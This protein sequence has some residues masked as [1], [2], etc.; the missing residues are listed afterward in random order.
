[1]GSVVKAEGWEGRLHLLIEGARNRAFAWGTHDCVTFAADA[2]IAQTGHDPISDVRG[3]WKTAR[4]AQLAMRAVDGGFGPA[5]ASR[6]GVPVALP[7]ASR[8][9][10]IRVPSENGPFLA[11]VDLSGTAACA[12]GKSGLVWVPLSSASAAWRI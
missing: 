3:T 11:I 4:G 10:L 2:V 8:G 7:L 6:C 9:D 5:I 1:V 12:P